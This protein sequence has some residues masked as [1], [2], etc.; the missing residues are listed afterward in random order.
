M[1]KLIAVLALISPFAANAKTITV[2]G[3]R[4]QLIA[5]IAATAELGDAAMGGRY[6]VTLKDV[7]CSKIVADD[8]GLTKCLIGSADNGQHKNVTLS[9]EIED[10]RES[11]ENLRVILQELT[12]A[13][14]K[15]SETEKRL[16]LASIKCHEAGRNHIYDALELEASHVCVIQTK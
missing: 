16:E 13:E 2:H 1:K 6:D 15:V 5:N 7:T 8:V 14:K 10:Q 9:S 4:A 12:G 3:I 11:A